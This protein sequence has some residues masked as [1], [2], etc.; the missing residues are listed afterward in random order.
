M[1]TKR[2]FSLFLAIILVVGL[3]PAMSIGL[4]AEE[5][6]GPVTVTGTDG[7][8][9][10]VEKT[11]FKKG[12][13]I[14]VT[15]VADSYTAWV[16]FC[17]SGAGTYPSYHYIGRS[18]SGAPFNVIHGKTYDA[19]EY[20][21]YLVPTRNGSYGNNVAK[22][23]VTITDEAYTEK[24][25]Y[26]T[27][28]F[29]TDLLKTKDNQRVFKKG[30]P[31]L[32][33]AT[34]TSP[35][36][37]NGDW[38]ANYSDI[39]D[40]SYDKYLY[41][42]NMGGAESYYD[43]SKMYTF[44]PGTH[45]IR[46]IDADAPLTGYEN[47]SLAGIYITVIDEEYV[48]PDEP[49][50]PTVPEKSLSV[51]KTE[52][53]EG[54]AIMITA[55]G[56]GSDWVG[57]ATADGDVAI[58]WYYV[59]FYQN[60][61]SP[62][63]GKE[64][65][66]KDML[67][68]GNYYWGGLYL[69]TETL[70]IPAGEY[71]IYYVENNANLD[72]GYLYS[73]PITVVAAQGGGNEG[74]GGDN[75]SGNEG[76]GDDNQGGSGEITPPEIETTDPVTVSNSTHSLS[77][78]KTKYATGEEILVTATGTGSKDWIGIAVRGTREATVRWIYIS[79]AG[80]GVPYDIRTA[81]NVG[82]NLGELANLPD[83]L[84]TVYLVE[85]DQ[86][87]KNDFT[88]GINISVGAVEDTENGAIQSNKETGGESTSVTSPESATYE[89]T[90]PKGY[91]GG[92]V[93]VTMPSDNL[94]N[95]GIVMFWA[96]ENGI[97]EG[98][99]PHAK[100]KVT[101]KQTTFTI[102]NSTVIPEN[103]TKLLV[104]SQ[105]NGSSVLSEKFV[106][107]DLP[108]NSGMSILGT[109]ITSFMII[110]DIHIGRN[111]TSAINFKKMLN[112][113]IAQKP[114][115][116]AIYIV[117]DMAD[118]GYESQFA[119]MMSLYFEVLTENGKEASSYPL[120]MAIGNHDYPSANGAFLQYATL[121][122]G[123]HPTDTSYDFWLNGFHYI[124]LGSDNPS[125]LY[126]YLNDDTLAWLD[127]KLSENRD[128][129]RP[130]FIFLHQSLYNT[131][132]GSLPGEGWNGVSNDDALR[133]VLANY[134]EAIMFNGHSHW[135]MDS[136]G[137]MYEATEELPINIFN[138]A[139]V[140]YLWSGYNYVGGENLEGSQ[141]YYV[142]IYEDRIL[143][144]GRDFISN[145][146]ISSAQ[147]CIERNLPC[148]HAY[149]SS[150][151]TYENG[152]MEKGALIS[153]CSVCG[154]TQE[155]ECEPL[156]TFLGYSIKEGSFA[157]CVSY[158]VEREL[159]T[160]YEELND[161]EITHGVVATVYDNL[162]DKNSPVNGD[163]TPSALTQGSSIVA[164]MPDNVYSVSLRITSNSWSTYESLKLILAGFIIEKGQVKYIC[165]DSLSASPA[166]VTYL[167]VK[168]S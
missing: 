48:S 67:N 88:F 42:R 23:T 74:E 84:Y 16:G 122:D 55:T 26:P 89:I 36:H 5:S 9:L 151:I 12:E 60:Y 34:D 116:T 93:T 135:T 66:I 129:S 121:P 125:G 143:V 57:I 4:F 137:N 131:V 40:T 104:Y 75:E 78:N 72:R 134:P 157:I 165:G 127:S 86:Y 56:S 164:K 46:L 145:K 124:F 147:Y 112:D 109:P 35:S 62:G 7:S 33:S 80:N 97:L 133:A 83:G 14:M 49:E 146:W 71:V 29:G 11:T 123:T 113:A 13:P 28:N 161:T 152:Y 130:T 115:G 73:I 138:C 144:K 59:D 163:G 142:E 119:D 95:H 87:L 111:E 167:E 38:I 132:S 148:D 65:N 91:A 17:P 69:G 41:V 118:S 31:I 47:N 32:V 19:G 106:T 155:T 1:K 108:Q 54:E 98:Y 160:L 149:E 102:I 70:N 94:T 85:N 92:T 43:I 63:S 61:F 105:I 50:E 114:N 168:A 39:Y 100:F 156:F 166:P 21:I 3:F 79:D 24:E 6:D 154:S 53:T 76:G 25:V 82:G 140:S 2:L 58:L 126:S 10:S 101:G 128:S 153:V 77:V 45:L 15:A 22:I 90:A 139:S 120:Y 44:A 107:I 64:F 110:S 103:A 150:Q 68:Y 141:G 18:G 37:A 81:P 136:K 27:V 99:T 8:S 159:L 96:N 52:F 20:D 162:V 51:N 158:K 117:G 30:E